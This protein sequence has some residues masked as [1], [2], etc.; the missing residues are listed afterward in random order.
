MAAGNM[1]LTVIVDWPIS[2]FDWP[3]LNKCF[4]GTCIQQ[5]IYLITDVNIV[6]QS[7]LERRPR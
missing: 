2:S 3:S 5:Y 6:Q 7:R 4:V 1:A